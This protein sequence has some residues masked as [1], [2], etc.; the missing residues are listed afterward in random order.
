MIYEEC[1]LVV[2][3]ESSDKNQELYRMN[4]RIINLERKD[5][6]GILTRIYL[7]ES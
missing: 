6:K 7:H 4:N 2:D 1:H 5:S 3:Y